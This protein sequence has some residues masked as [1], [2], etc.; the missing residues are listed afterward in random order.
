MINLQRYWKA[1]FLSSILILI[2]FLSFPSTVM[3]IREMI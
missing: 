2:G 1:I 3:A